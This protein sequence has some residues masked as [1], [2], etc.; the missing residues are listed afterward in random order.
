MP[1]SCHNN[2]ASHSN[3]VDK[4]V[5]TL[6]AENLWFHYSDEIDAICGV[7]FRID[8][9]E[10][11]ALCGHNGCGKTTLLKLF[12][13]IL[14]PTQGK[15][16][17]S[18]VELTPCASREL[19]RTVGL[20]FQDS[21][22]QLFCNEV[23]EDIA[24]GPRNMGFSDSDIS[25]KVNRALSITETE[26]LAHRPVHH[27]SGGEMKR[28]ALAGIIAMDPPILILD[29]PF[30]GLDPAATSKL[31]A[32][33]RNLTTNH[34]YTL[35]MTTHQMSLVP[36]VAARMLVMQ[37]GR[38][39]ADGPVHDLL[40]NIPLLE[41]ARLEPPA[42]TKYFYEKSVLTGKK[43]AWLPLTLDEA[44]AANE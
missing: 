29:E 2:D 36:E 22:N 32:I 4:R 42:I 38:I 25:E 19:F 12:A 5:A 40:T 7:N 11:V 13:G 17:V 26:H 10:V 21:Q 31:V 44:I 9:D 39:I 34:G 33:I 14:R 6:E 24:Y 27:L 15:V 18:G 8:A 37:Q 16:R 43:P 20:L 3:Q 41:Q 28:V 1:E 30:S 23:Y 35:L